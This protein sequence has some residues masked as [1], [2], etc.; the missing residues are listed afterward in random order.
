MATLA[1]RTSIPRLLLKPL[2]GPQLAVGGIMV[3]LAGAAYCHGYQR[4]LTGV[5]PGPWSGSLMWSAFAVAPWFALFEWSKHERGSSVMRR[6]AALI[7][8]VLALAVV[9]I[10]SE[11]LVS[12][13]VGEITDQLGLLI[14]RRVPAIAFSAVLIALARRSTRG[15]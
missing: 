15:Q 14:M 2:S 7:A 13:C 1:P 8:L 10:A 12:F 4:L 5:N 3:W 11:Y 9:S 6:P